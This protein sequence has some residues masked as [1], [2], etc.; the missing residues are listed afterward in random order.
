[1]AKVRTAEAN[2]E[3]GSAL[4]ARRAR[5]MPGSRPSGQEMQERLLARRLLMSRERKAEIEK[6]ASLRLPN[7][8][9]Q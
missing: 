5:Q 7:F 4:L 1:V 9:Q 3:D 6:L 2:G 8:H